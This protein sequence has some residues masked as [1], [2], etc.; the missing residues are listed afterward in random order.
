MIELRGLV[1]TQKS[2]SFGEVP[3]FETLLVLKPKR[4]VLKP[5]T[6]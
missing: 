5:K 6:H 2:S 1:F 3:V 4:A